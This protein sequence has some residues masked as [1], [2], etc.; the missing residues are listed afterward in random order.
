M[1][2][3]AAVSFGGVG[4]K[5]RDA[6]RMADLE[7]IRIALEMFKQQ[8]V[9]SSYPA[10]C[11]GSSC[12]LVTGGFLQSWPVGPKNDV[13]TYTRTPTNYKYTI[14]ATVEDAGSSNVAGGFYRLSNP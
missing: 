11:S 8:S 14:Q 12:I 7:K 3:I 5:S 6:R 1:T 10:T 13:Y 4:R 9:G 2:V